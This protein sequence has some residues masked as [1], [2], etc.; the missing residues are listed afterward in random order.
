MSALFI[1]DNASKCKNGQWTSIDKDTGAGDLRCF[2][3]LVHE[4]MGGLPVTM[5]TKN[6]KGVRCEG[7]K[8]ID[9]EYT[10]P[11]LEEVFERNCTLRKV[12]NSGPYKGVPIVAVPLMKGNEAVAV[13]GCVDIT[14]GAMFDM[15]NKTWG[16]SLE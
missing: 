6:S 13:I 14:R 12:S 2:A 4:L 1:I 8:I 11:V 16:R 10:G 7:G 5:R 15:L 3:L 9:F